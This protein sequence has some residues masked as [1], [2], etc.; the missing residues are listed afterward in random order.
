MKEETRRFLAPIILLGCILIIGQILIAFVGNFLNLDQMLSSTATTLL[1]ST[2]R[3]VMENLDERFNRMIRVGSQIA[4]DEQFSSYDRTETGLSREEQATLEVALGRALATYSALDNFSDC[5]VVFKD[6]THL[7]QLDAHTEELYSGGNLL[8]DTFKETG[9]RDAQNFFI[10]YQGDY[11]RIYFAKTVNAGTLVLISIL[12]ES[13][14]PIFYDAEENYSLTLH[15]STKDHHI[16]YSGNKD[17]SMSGM[18]DADLAQ[19]IESSKHTSIEMRGEVIASDTCLNGF[20]ITSTI[21]ENTLTTENGN[22]KALY[23]IISLVI[24][25]L[26]IFVFILLCRRIIRRSRELSKIE[27]NLE[28]FTNINE[29]NIDV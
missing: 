6:S 2:N 23:L 10:G 12:S 8:Y 25:A 11:S 16:L 1:S 26:M 21:S 19:T 20:R 14:N 17:E 9:E 18:L 15:L 24:I 28:D 27:D 3:E 5:C 7:G 13:M 29:I 4:G 22:L